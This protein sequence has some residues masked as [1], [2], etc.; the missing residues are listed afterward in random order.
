VICT[1]LDRIPE[2][3]TGITESC[4]GRL[5]LHKKFGYSKLATIRL[6]T[7]PW[8]ELL[9]QVIKRG[10]YLTFQCTFFIPFPPSH[11]ATILRNKYAIKGK[12]KGKFVRV[13]N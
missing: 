9:K 11:H 6:A 10:I 12:V 3:P 2:P 4:S 7:K 1:F 8:S 5:H 13:L